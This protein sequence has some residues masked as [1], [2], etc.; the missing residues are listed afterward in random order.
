[1]NNTHQQLVSVSFVIISQKS[2][3]LF[4]HV[5]H[6]FDLVHYQMNKWC[7]VYNM[8]LI[9]KSLF[10]KKGKTLFS[11][12]FLVFKSIKMVKKQFFN[13]LTVICDVHWIFFK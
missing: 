4:N 11:Y 2:F 10:K 7:H 12:E 9:K 3:Q 5:V 13:W 1:L 6:D 8:S